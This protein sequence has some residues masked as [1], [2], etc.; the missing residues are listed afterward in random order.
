M[1]WASATDDPELKAVYL[2]LAAGYDQL[3][4]FQQSMGPLMA[5]IRRAGPGRAKGQ[6]GLAESRRRRANRGSGRSRYAASGRVRSR[7]T[8]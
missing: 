1:L 7:P 4:E 5:R 8:A 2:R 3:A 6:G